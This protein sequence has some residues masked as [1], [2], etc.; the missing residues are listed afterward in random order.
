MA[1]RSTADLGGGA[2]GRFFVEPCPPHLVTRWF[3]RFHR[4]AALPLAGTSCSC[5][6]SLTPHRGFGSVDGSVFTVAQRARAN[7]VF[8]RRSSRRVVAV[9]V[10]VV[11]GSRR[12]FVPHGAHAPWNVSDA[13]PVVHSKEHELRSI[14]K[15]SMLQGHQDG[16]SIRV[17]VRGL[18]GCYFVARFSDY[19]SA[20]EPFGSIW[21]QEFRDK[22]LGLR[23]VA[24]T[25]RVDKRLSVA[26]IV[27]VYQWGVYFLL[28]GNVTVC[29]V[30]P[31]CYTV[32]SLLIEQ[33]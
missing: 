11:V 23:P 16:G 1:C 3:S 7:L 10:V 31:Y 26:S 17:Q 20:C 27:I 5:A 14:T 32:S 15:L 19:P 18:A 2:S 22:V 8:W 9:A 30:F 25:H 28:W 6:G 4:D 13:C 12:S 33:N 24:P 21:N 29:S